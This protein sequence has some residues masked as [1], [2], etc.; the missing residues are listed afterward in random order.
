MKMLGAVRREAS[1]VESDDLG[2]RINELGNK[3]TQL[4]LS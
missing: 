4:L 2:M 1:S 3:S